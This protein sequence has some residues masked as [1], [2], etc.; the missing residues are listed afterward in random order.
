M[1]TIK[2]F[3]DELEILNAKIIIKSL[4]KKDGNSTRAEALYLSILYGL[5]KAPLTTEVE[6]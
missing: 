5:D 6:K 4:I 2:F 1:T 3:V